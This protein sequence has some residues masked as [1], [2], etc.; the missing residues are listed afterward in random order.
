MAEISVIEFAY[1]ALWKFRVEYDTLVSGTPF[2]ASGSRKVRAA[3][4]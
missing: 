3:E 2:L 4:R 1:S